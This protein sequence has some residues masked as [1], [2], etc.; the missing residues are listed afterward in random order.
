MEGAIS[1]VKSLLTLR[2][3]LLF[4]CMLW[5]SVCLQA[6]SSDPALCALW[7]S[8]P[9]DGIAMYNSAEAVAQVSLLMLCCV[10]IHADT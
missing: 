8:E 5:N 4:C 7:S 6:Y 1:A 2:S 10:C 3:V 9:N